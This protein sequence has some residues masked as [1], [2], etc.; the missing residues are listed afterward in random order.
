VEDYSEEDVDIT[1]LEVEVSLTKSKNEKLLGNIVVPVAEQ[2]HW[3]PM[4]VTLDTL[5]THNIT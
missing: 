2:G 5:G 1:M 3:D 4:A